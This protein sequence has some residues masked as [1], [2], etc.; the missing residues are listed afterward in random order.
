LQIENTPMRFATKF[1]VSF[2]VTIPF[3]SRTRMSSAIPAV[4]A[5]SVKRLA[6]ISTSRM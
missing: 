4:T 1:V 3:P 2:A 6:T 5:G